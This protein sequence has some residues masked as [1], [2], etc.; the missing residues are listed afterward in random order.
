M[1]IPTNSSKSPILGPSAAEDLPSRQGDGAESLTAALSSSPVPLNSVANSNGASPASPNAAATT[2]PHSASTP[3]LQSQGSN[4]RPRN[5]HAGELLVARVGEWL[6]HERKKISR[7]KDGK[8]PLR[9]IQSVDEQTNGQDVQPIPYRDRADSIDSQSSEVSFDRLQRILED[10]VAAM[11]L[12]SIP[13]MGHMHRTRSSPRL[14]RGQTKTLQLQRV[15]SSDTDQ[16]DLDVVVPAC[17]AVLDNS[18]TMSYSGGSASTE[19]L[20]SSTTLSKR[21]SRGRQAWITFK[22]EVIRLA[23]T[24]RLKGWRS[25]PL[26]GGE[27]ISVERLSGA[28]TNAVYVVSPPK[29]LDLLPTNGTNG[30]NGTGTPTGKKGPKK[31]LLRIYGPQVDQLIDRETELAVLR[32]LAKKKIG[33]RLLGTFTNGRFEE[34]FNASALHPRDLRDPETSKQIAKRMREL[35]D[36]VEL[37]DTERD[38][39]PNVWRNWDRWLDSVGKRASALDT[40]FESEDAG[41]ER[42]VENWRIRG[43]V[44]GV[45]W[46]QFKAIVEKYREHVD[47]FYGEGNTLRSR[48]VFA[49]NDVCSFLLSFLSP[50]SPPYMELC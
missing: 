7:R 2:V 12:S 16:F 33:P 15:P 20:S 3:N 18:K 34:Y 38:S 44:C 23:H 19:D 31:L 47:K 9:N 24:L 22:N 40:L 32:R 39:G 48:L 28:L 46:A 49:H 6:E 37:L 14:R 30:T 45:P 11:G 26:D 10:S 29:D 21:E 4:G 41:P 1:P 43:R 35:H 17:E 13:S 50:S 27:K 5:N 42:P 36:G 8:H 25:V